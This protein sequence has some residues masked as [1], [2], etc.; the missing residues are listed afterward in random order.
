MNLSRSIAASMSAQDLARV[1]EVVDESDKLHLAFTP[2]DG[3]VSLSRIY[4]LRRLPGS[5]TASISRPHPGDPTLLLGNTF[6]FHVATRARL[7]TQLDVCSQIA[8]TAPLFQVTSRS[9][10]GGRRPVLNRAGP[11]VDVLMSQSPAMHSPRKKPLSDVLLVIPRK[12]DAGSGD[13]PHVPP[14]AVAAVASWAAAARGRGS[15]RDAAPAPS[16]GRRSYLAAVRL[17]RAVT[18]TLPLLPSD[19][20]CL[21]RSLVLTSVLARRGLPS[22][23][24]I[25]SG[26]MAGSRRMPG[27][28]TTGK[29]VPPT[30]HDDVL[31][32]AFLRSEA[33][34]ATAAVA[35][36]LDLRGAAT[37]PYRL[38]AA[39]G[40]EPARILRLG[41]L[42]VAVSDGVDVHEDG[43]VVCCLL[44]SVL[45]ADAFAE[46]F[47]LPLSSAPEAALAAGDQRQGTGV[48]DTVRG[49]FFVVLWDRETRQGL[50]A[51]DQL[52]QRAWYLH[53]AGAAMT[54]ASEVAPLLASLAERPAPDPRGLVRWLTFRSMPRTQ[55]VQRRPPAA[56][57]AGRGAVRG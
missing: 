53:L 34:P 10:D 56:D 45:E 21:M 33:T 44:G 26:P 14:G 31:W 12:A 29:P 5:G 54:F 46:R 50:L 43:R 27:S 3:P 39:V 32:G 49:S 24:V 17:G 7:I 4:F 51:Q 2:G 13:R 22:T 37:S 15:A 52:S 36:V 6:V 47:G 23:V 25:A 55:H 1:G 9:A 28:S 48:L 40:G 41:P 35:G 57:R 11:S 16:T 30:T 42:T 19:S 18:R 38:V 8:Q 20:R